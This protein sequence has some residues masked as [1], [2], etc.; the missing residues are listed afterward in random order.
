MHL[1]VHMAGLCACTGSLLRDT[2]V[3]YVTP[4]PLYPYL[5]QAEVVGVQLHLCSCDIVFVHRG[6]GPGKVHRHFNVG[7]QTGVLRGA[8]ICA[9]QPLKI[10]SNHLPKRIMDRS[11][12]NCKETTTHASYSILL[13]RARGHMSSI[14][15]VHG[16]MACALPSSRPP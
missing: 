1:G 4:T 8:G 6:L 9:T 14:A 13:A 15:A 3:E 12:R 11:C 10:P 16:R 5:V 2:C 7:P